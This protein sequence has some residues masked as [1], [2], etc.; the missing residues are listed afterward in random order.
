MRKLTI[1]TLGGL[2]AFGAVMAMATTL[3]GLTPDTLGAQNAPVV[4]CD[5]DGVATSY[6]SDWDATDERYEV[7]TVNV[8]GIADT[9]DGLTVKVTVT[10]STGASLSEG[11]LLIPTNATV[12]H[13]VALAAGVSTEAI[14]NVH[15]TIA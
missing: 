11:T 13:P 6:T 7:A 1:K 4:A 12:D 14:T 2:T 5:A 3:G 8:N 10:D 9:C 15:V